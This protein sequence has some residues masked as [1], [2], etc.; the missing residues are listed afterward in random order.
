MNV[1]FSDATLL[2]L[3]VLVIY[4]ISAQRLLTSAPPSQK[5]PYS[6]V[7]HPLLQFYHLLNV[8]QVM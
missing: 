1:A 7:S 4:C 3:G 5:S 2:L 8:N 6:T